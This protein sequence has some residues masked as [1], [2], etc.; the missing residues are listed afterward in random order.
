MV[1]FEN[2]ELPDILEV[3]GA[4]QTYDGGKTYVLKDF[5]LLIEDKPAQGQFVVLLGPSGCGKSTVLRYMAGLQTPTKGEIYIRE[6]LRTEQDRIGMVFQQY[7]SFPWMT[8]LENV[9]LGLKYKGVPEKE[10]NERAMEMIQIVG[11]EG[12]HKKYAQYP[13]LSGGQLQRVAIARSLLV[14]PEIILMDEPF[15]AL[16]TNTRLKMQDFLISVWEKVHPTIVLVTHDISEAVYLG[17]D[18]YIMGTAPS[19]IIEHVHIDLPFDRTKE[20]KRSQRFTE[21]VFY[22]EDRMMSFDV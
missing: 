9:A 18:V 4:D 10:R 5:N 21:L 11:L 17:D 19:N 8:V 6:K 14:N 7:S 3:R 1:T 13:T 20:I 15:G 16:D 22:L 12:H 2:T